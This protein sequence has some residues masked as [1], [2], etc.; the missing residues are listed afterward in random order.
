MREEGRNEPEKPTSQEDHKSFMG[1]FRLKMTP[2]DLEKLDFAYDM[3]KYGH[4]NQF[5]ESGERYFEHL[6]ATSLILVDELGVTDVEMIIASLLH[7]MLEDSFLLNVVRIK[8]AF[9]ERVAAI[10]D[11][12]S[13]PRKSDQR[14]GSD[15]ERHAWYF[16][17]IARSDV[18]SLIVKMADRL[19]NMRTLGCCSREKQRRKIDETNTVYL[20]LLERISQEYPKQ[21]AILTEQFRIVIGQLEQSLGQQ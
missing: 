2:D 6:R 7:D 21:A 14:F 9:G 16:E 1:R 11:A 3:A 4:R 10:V 15:R 12:I 18:Y 13:K 20:P 8:I 17:Q 19:H 5:R